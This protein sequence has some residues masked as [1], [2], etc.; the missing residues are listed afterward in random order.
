MSRLVINLIFALVL[1]SH[2]SPVYSQ[3]YGVKALSGYWKMQNEMNT[4]LKV[5]PSGGCG[6][7]AS[8]LENGVRK[9]FTGNLYEETYLSMVENGNN[10]RKMIYTGRMNEEGQIYGKFYSPDCRYGDFIWVK[11]C[12]EYGNPLAIEGAELIPCAETPA[13]AMTIP[14]AQTQTRGLGTMITTQ[15]QVQQVVER[16]EYVGEPRNENLPLAETVRDVPPGAIYAGNIGLTE[17]VIY[18]TVEVEVPVEVVPVVCEPQQ[19]D[20]TR[21]LT[22][23]GFSFCDPGSINPVKTRSVAIPGKEVNENG[24]TYHI[25][26]KLETMYSISKRYNLTIVELAELNGK[27]C[28]HLMEGEKL[29]VSK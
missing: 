22:S 16:T 8:L 1:L 24:T 6:F 13:T 19:Q 20:G 4:M 3:S 26:G 7:N 27:D 15:K 25:V 12:D 9:E 10:S 23:G 17:K 21:G 11:I 29:R 2:F 5:S 18:K 14:S 28:E